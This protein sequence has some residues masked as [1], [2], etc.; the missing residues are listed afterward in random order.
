MRQAVRHVSH[1]AVSHQLA[2]L[3][4]AGAS[5]RYPQGLGVTPPSPP[6]NDATPISM[7]NWLLQVQN[8]ITARS[9]AAQACGVSNKPCK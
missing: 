3:V 4:R 6:P 5:A 1:A 2:P 8:D 9:S 7:A